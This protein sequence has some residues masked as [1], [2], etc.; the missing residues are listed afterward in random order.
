MPGHGAHRE[1]ESA[2]PEHWS[3]LRQGHELYNV[4]HHYEAAVA[5]ADATGKDNLLAVATKSA[6]FVADTFGPDAL[7]GVPGHEE[8]EL[9]LMRLARK[10]G[11]SRY[12]ELA[13]F[14]LD[15]RG[16][17]GRGDAGAP[18]AQFAE[19]DPVPPTDPPPPIASPKYPHE[20]NRMPHANIH[21]KDRRR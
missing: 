6:D 12:A 21:T 19:T 16:K 9:G 5:Y 11:R 8:I 7:V 17:A 13:R 20:V 1:S 18:H 2:G 4:G 10:T 15:A 14:S 3:N